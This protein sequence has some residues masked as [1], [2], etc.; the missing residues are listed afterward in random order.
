MSTLNVSLPPELKKIVDERVEQIRK[1]QEQAEREQLE[2]KLLARLQQP[3]K[4]V[5]AAD[6]DAIR[7]R[8]KTAARKSPKR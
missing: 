3:S 5:T 4:P 7:K 8:L 1:D 2:A 6:F